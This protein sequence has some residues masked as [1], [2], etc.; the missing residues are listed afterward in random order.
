MWIKLSGS[1][2]GNTIA[3]DTSPDPC[4]RDFRKFEKFIFRST[5][6]YSALD[7]VCWLF[8]KPNQGRIRIHTCITIAPDTSLGPCSR[9]FEEF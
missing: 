3:P 5:N 1:E 9:D 4:S 8:K 7:H 6:I 2:T